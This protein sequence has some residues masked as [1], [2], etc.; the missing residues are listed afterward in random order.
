MQ[1]WNFS[2]IFTY[3]GM[4]LYNVSQQALPYEKLEFTQVPLNTSQ[5]R[6][7]IEQ[8][9]LSFSKQEN[10][11]RGHTSAQSRSNN[12]ENLVDLFLN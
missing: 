6:A 7:Q 2:E 4:N 10:S 9:C 8:F 1:P 11:L 3:N 5:E 12:K